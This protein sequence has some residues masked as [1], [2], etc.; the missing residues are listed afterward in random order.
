MGL[1]KS[2]RKKNKR[3]MLDDKYTVFMV[4]AEDYLPK[5]NDAVKEII[6]DLSASENADGEKPLKQT[7]PFATFKNAEDFLNELRTLS[8]NESSPI[9]FKYMAIWE[10]D[11]NQKPKPGKPGS[12]SGNPHE[13][14][15][16]PNFKVSYDFENL[17]KV[18]FESIFNDPNNDD[19]PYDEKKQ[20]AESL[21]EAYMNSLGVGEDQV[22]HIPTEAETSRGAVNLT[23]PAYADVQDE[24]D[25]G[26]TPADT[27]TVYDPESNTFINPDEKSVASQSPQS[28]VPKDNAE[29]AKDK[30]VQNLSEDN[31]DKNDT[32][33]VIPSREKRAN[34]RT[35]NDEV[36]DETAEAR[37][38][39]YV[40]APQFAVKVLD[41]VNPGQ[42]GYVDYQLNQ[43]KKT[44]N[45]YLKNLEKKIN[46]SNEK[47]I[48]KQRESYRKAAAETIA[49]FKEAHKNDLDNL[50]DDIFHKLY[51]K[52]EDESK[53]E[54]TKIDDQ[55]QLELKEAQR[56]YE[57]QQ[58]QIHEDAKANRADLEKRLTAKYD[59]LATDQFTKDSE[60]LLKQ[61]EQEQAKLQ[62]QQDR[63]YEIKAREDAAQLRINGQQAL[64]KAME[65]YDHQLSKVRTKV[66]A[67]D[68]NAQQTVTAAKRAE[69]ESKRVDAPYQEI[70]EANQTI[71]DLKAQ[72]SKVTTERDNYQKES[73]DRHTEV[74]N[75]NHKLDAARKDY[76]ALNKELINQQMS[77]SNKTSS[78]N[79]NRMVQLMI[80]QQL[81]NQKPENKQQ[82]SPQLKTLMKGAKRTMIGGITVLVLLIA[83][84]TGLFI[85]QQ[86]VNNA[87]I[88]S[89]TNTMNR[90]V[91]EAK[92]A[93]AT[94]QPSQAEVDKKALTALHAND[95]NALN[96]LQTET[97]YQLDKAIID[98]N[99]DAAN[100]AVSAMGDNLKMNDR[101]RSTQAENLLK[102]AHNDDLANKVADANK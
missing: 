102:N 64:Q 36:N 32:D 49:Q 77:N 24:D 84:G 86:N 56:A 10:F 67:E 85:H 58:E 30:A 61:N 14:I 6:D 37:Q 5:N 28:Q 94:P 20:I 23:I 83:G 65:H 18:L 93:K 22:A 45:A 53:K 26:E 12:G 79:L 69:T 44:Y 95:S 1:F 31:I 89:L 17:T 54:N 90:R 8:A 40:E 74:K 3:T 42:P 33:L 68:M 63:K 101:Y 100:A 81:A 4:L 78:D 70:R 46:D 96:K 48:V 73:V 25:V 43:Q 34:K 62:K 35:I 52:K 92:A 39:G 2:L 57:K 91:A 50:H 82:E 71:S 9:P 99:A 11:K 76:S 87:R 19:V 55:E 38:K 41:P 97:Y 13:W 47:A 75:L 15:T 27:T 7:L 88:A 51:A 66:T 60:K 80:T 16:L 72:L 21:K 59:K 29:S 98:N